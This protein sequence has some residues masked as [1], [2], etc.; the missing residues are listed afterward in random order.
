MQNQLKR[1]NQFVRTIPRKKEVY[2]P[3]LQEILGHFQNEQNIKGMILLRAFQNKE[4]KLQKMMFLE[5]LK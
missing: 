2:L 4:I 1:E 5:I 3:R